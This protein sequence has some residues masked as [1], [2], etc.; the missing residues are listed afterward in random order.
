[1]A[2]KKKSPLH[3]ITDPTDPDYVEKIDD[4]EITDEDLMKSDLFAD[5]VFD[6]DITKFGSG[7]Q[8]V[9]TS[10]IDKR[11]SEIEK[12]AGTSVWEKQ[13]AYYRQKGEGDVLRV[14]KDVASL[15]LPTIALWQ[16]REA[17]A[18]AK[19]EMLKQQM[20]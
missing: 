6:T 15:F 13:A 16:E 2:I 3:E 1:M 4:T 18:S 17:T 10:G 9:D 5:T 8:P 7:V 14:Q 11:I 19:F 12:P 20:P